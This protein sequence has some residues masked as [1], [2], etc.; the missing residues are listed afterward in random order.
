MHVYEYAGQ[1]SD[2]GLHTKHPQVSFATLCS[3]PGFKFASVVGERMA[4]LTERV[5]IRHDILFFELERP[6]R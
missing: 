5:A 4:D 3:G 2:M 6:L 1:H